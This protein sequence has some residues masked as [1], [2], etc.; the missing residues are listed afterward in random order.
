MSSISQLQS[1]LSN[2]RGKSF[3]YRTI[4][5]KNQASANAG[6]FRFY[7]N[8]PVPEL[9]SHCLASPGFHIEITGC[10]SSSSCRLEITVSKEDGF[11]HD[12]FHS[13]EVFADLG[14]NNTLDNAIERAQSVLR[15]FSIRPIL[16][17]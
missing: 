6:V 7:G 17:L 5:L 13:E 4:T 16:A 11:Y 12:L 14:W 1:A 10:H 2:C 15:D 8:I 9:A 3:R